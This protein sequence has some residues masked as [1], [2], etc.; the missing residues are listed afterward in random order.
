MG[1][2][3]LDRVTVDHEHFN[4]ILREHGWTIKALGED[5]DVD[6]SAKLIQGYLHEGG[7]PSFLV[8]RI[9]KKLG[10]TVRELVRP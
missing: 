9:A 3:M 8:E 5:R 10:V 6:R 4:K 7:M 1:K 2:R